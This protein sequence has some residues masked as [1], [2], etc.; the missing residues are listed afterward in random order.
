VARSRDIRTNQS[1]LAC[2]IC[3]RTLLRGEHA[4]VFLAGGS[5]RM[6]CEL[7]TARAAHEG[8]IREGLDDA[9]VRA[10]AEQGRSRGFFARLRS[11]RGHDAGPALERVREAAEPPP[12]WAEDAGDEDLDTVAAP[13]PE[14][15][16]PHPHPVAAHATHQPQ[17][18]QAPREQRSVHAIPTNAD[19]KMARALDLFN[20]SPHPRTVAGVARSLGSP[21]VAVR[22]SPTEGSVVTIVVGWELSWYRFE[23]DLGDEA[24]GVRLV[25]QGAELSELEPA[26]QIA[27]AGADDQ[28][29]L[30]LA[31]QHA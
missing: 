29:E 3:G 19:L 31:A 11:R 9:T 2:D 7:C 17:A 25:T 12:G 4:D 26:D 27:N 18:S 15:V 5:R 21:I 20:A 30:H 28:G 23:V 13:A 6:V 1:D 8:W 22:P 14:P 10:G 24:A 16:Q